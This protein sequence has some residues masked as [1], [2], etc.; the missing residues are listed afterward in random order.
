MDGHSAVEHRTRPLPHLLWTS[1]GPQVVEIRTPEQVQ[2]A[3]LPAAVK[4]AQHILDGFSEQLQEARGMN[5]LDKRISFSPPI[6]ILTIHQESGESAMRDAHLDRVDHLA[7]ALLLETFSPSVSEANPPVF[8]QRALMTEDAQ[9][10]HFVYFPTE[11]PGFYFSYA[12]KKSPLG[13]LKD[14]WETEFR[15][16]YVP[17]AWQKKLQPGAGKVALFAQAGLLPPFRPDT[18]ATHAELFNKQIM[19]PETA[20]SSEGFSKN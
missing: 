14:H 1:A 13:G 15:L 20:I 5:I 6:E 7:Q 4:M 10:N 12:L 2:D 19:M 16:A 18:L 3:R 11:K 9:G 17:E 8:S